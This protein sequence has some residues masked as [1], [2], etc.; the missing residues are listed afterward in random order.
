MS[1]NVKNI[2]WILLASILIAAF[3]LMGGCANKGE[4]TSSLDNGISLSTSGALAGQQEENSS[5]TTG[6]NGI[7]DGS[8]QRDSDNKNSAKSDDE[9][10]DEKTDSPKTNH[11]KPPQIIEKPLSCKITITCETLLANPDKIPPGKRQLIPADGVILA[12][13][14]IEFK[15]GESAFDILARA[16]R[17]NGIHMEFVKTPIYNSA[18]IEGIHNLYEFD[19]GEASGWMYSIN[20]VFPQR[21]SS[22]CIIEAN[23]RIHWVYSCDLGRDVGGYFVNQKDE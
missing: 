17:D 6:D 15:R 8:N 16:T 23:D 1:D 18:Y 7:I 12:P 11:E 2:I 13:T 14:K 21:G 9:K 3:L 4:A 19:G 10:T 22:T 20:G 5:E